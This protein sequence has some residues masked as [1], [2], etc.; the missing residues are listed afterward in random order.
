MVARDTT[1]TINKKNLNG[2]RD[3]R[4]TINK[5]KIIMVREILD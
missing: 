5:K 1:L 2:A 4:L 3:T